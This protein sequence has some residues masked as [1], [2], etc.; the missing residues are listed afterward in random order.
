MWNAEWTRR[1]QSLCWSK[2]SS[3]KQRA[4]LRAIAPTL[5]FYSTTKQNGTKPIGTSGDSLSS[6]S[7]NNHHEISEASRKLDATAFVRS[8]ELTEN[9]T[10][11]GNDGNEKVSGVTKEHINGIGGK[12]QEKED[13]YSG[14]DANE[15]ARRESN[16]Y[17]NG[18]GGSD[19]RTKH[20]NGGQRD[21]GNTG[22]V[23]RRFLFRFFQGFVF[24]GAGSGITWVYFIYDR[25]VAPTARDLCIDAIASSTCGL[26]NEQRSFFVQRPQYNELIDRFVKRDVERQPGYMIVAGPRGCGKSTLVLDALEGRKGVIVKRFA[27]YAD[28]RHIFDTLLSSC[29]PQGTV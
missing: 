11:S 13:R 26:D 12:M 27:N 9:I 23:W 16:D 1:G 15:E 7:A 3:V 18:N 19:R 22:S 24:I 21:N 4:L 6:L 25:H 10:S 29:L 5:H 28:T 14:K 17:S 8:V 2:R 20:T